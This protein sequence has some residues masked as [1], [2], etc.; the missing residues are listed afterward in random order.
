MKKI[1]NYSL[2]IIAGSAIAIGCYLGTTSQESDVSL[3]ELVEVADADA[4]CM[5]FGLL[6]GHCLPLLQVC[7]EGDGGYEGVRCDP[8]YLPPIEW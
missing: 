6:T 7:V 1:V 8:R 4:E 2:A 5:T 3:S